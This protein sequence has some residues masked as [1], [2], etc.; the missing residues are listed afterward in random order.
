MAVVAGQHTVEGVYVESLV[1][2]FLI[3]LIGF[4]NQ[5]D[6]LSQVC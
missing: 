1:V 5:F 2:N 4:Y 3:K 6:N